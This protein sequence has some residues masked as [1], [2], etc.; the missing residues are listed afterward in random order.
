MELTT[1][2]TCRWNAT[3]RLNN[4]TGLAEL[5]DVSCRV[6]SCPWPCWCAA[7][8]RAERVGQLTHSMQAIRV[9]DKGWG[10]RV[11]EPVKKAG[12]FLCR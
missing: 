3:T 8:Q 5:M 11:V 12:A 10:V 9:G 4:N 6:A 1:A 2:G 7:P